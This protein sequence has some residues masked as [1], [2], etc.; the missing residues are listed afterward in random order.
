MALFGATSL[1]LPLMLSQ[2]MARR[3]FVL[4][5]IGFIFLLDPINYQLGL[6]SLIG[7]FRQGRRSRF[8]ALL[9]SGFRLRLAMG[10][11]ELLGGC[12]VAL[13]L[14]HVPAVENL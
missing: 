3:L 10:V 1:L 4:V 8:Y 9:L 11:L 13:H 12:E 7:D 6:P 5:W 14:S 2:T